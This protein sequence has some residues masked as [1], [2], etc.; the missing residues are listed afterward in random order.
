LNLTLVL[1]IRSKSHPTKLIHL[2]SV[3]GFCSNTK[4]MAPKKGP[5]KSEDIAEISSPEGDVIS[6][7]KSHAIESIKSWRQIYENMEYEIKNSPN[8]SENH[9]QDIEESEL[10]KIVARPRL[11][12]YND[13]ISWV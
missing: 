1:S 4:V 3:T 9:L 5:K 10:H 11:M 6:D 2:S 7:T 13:M 8:D 12:A